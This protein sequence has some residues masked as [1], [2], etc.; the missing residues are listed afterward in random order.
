MEIT[1][2][3]VK[4][5]AKLAR[6]KLSDEE[7]K[8]FT[9]ELKEVLDAFGELDKVDTEGVIPSFHPVTVKNALREDVSGECLSQVEALE[10]ATHK[11]DGYFKGPRA[12]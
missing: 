12:V 5:I 6:I 1:A 2:D 10:N 7:I 3:V 8:K 9:P 11:K 4:H